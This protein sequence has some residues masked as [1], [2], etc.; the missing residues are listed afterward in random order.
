MLRF[1]LQDQQLIGTVIKTLNST[2]RRIFS[3]NMPVPE[4]LTELF[5]LDEMRQSIPLLTQD[6]HK[7]EAGRIGV[8]GGSMEYTGAPYFASISALRAG[9]DL[10]HVFCR[11]EAA[12]VIKSYSP[13]LIFHPLLDAPNAVDA[14]E[15]WLSRIHC[16]VLGPGQFSIFD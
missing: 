12:P 4:M 13:E 14:I 9:C 5:L 6:L 16:A 8:F 3:T 11:K 10:V 2:C 1:I 7:G 15:E